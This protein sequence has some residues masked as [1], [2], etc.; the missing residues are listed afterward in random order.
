MVG[1][2]GWEGVGLKV[3]VEEEKE[4][5]V[6]R[7]KIDLAMIRSLVEKTIL[8]SRLLSKLE[9]KLDNNITVY[10]SNFFSALT[11][12]NILYSSLKIS[13]SLLVSIGLLIA[14]CAPLI[15]YSIV[16]TIFLSILIYCLNK[17]RFIF[18][19]GIIFSLLL[20]LYIRNY[21]VIY[22]II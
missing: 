13:S 16:K 10:V 3:E 17:A 11:K 18:I 14:I 15:L 21:K 20:F 19:S 6:Q 2:V 22:S 4:Q 7:E 9:I 1:F 5:G 12:L 8:S